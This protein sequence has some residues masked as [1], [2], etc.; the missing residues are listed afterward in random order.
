LTTITPVVILSAGR[1]I[2]RHLAMKTTRTYTTKAEAEKERLRIMR[3]ATSAAASTT[4][5]FGVEK[6]RSARAKPVSLPSA[7]TAR[8]LGRDDS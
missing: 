8:K 7:E 4:N 5:N 2:Q 3:Q 6:V 1:S